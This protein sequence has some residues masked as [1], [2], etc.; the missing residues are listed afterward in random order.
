MENAIDRIPSS[1]HGDLSKKLVA[2]VLGTNDRDAVPA[3]L[4]K[5]IIYLWRQDQLASNV[6]IKTL[7]EAAQLV[8]VQSTVKLLEE[9][10]LKELAI[11]LKNFQ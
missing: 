8:D 6:G 10:G 5:K 4:A 9:H 3:D 11:I 1:L 2:I 7:L